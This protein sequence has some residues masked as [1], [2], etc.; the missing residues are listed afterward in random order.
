[1][2]LAHGD[3]HEYLVDKP[4]TNLPNFTRIQ[5]FGSSQVHWI[6]VNV[7]PKSGHVFSFIQKIVPENVDTG[8]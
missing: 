7:D 8:S 2:I 1:M 6:K 3:F 5:T 4:L